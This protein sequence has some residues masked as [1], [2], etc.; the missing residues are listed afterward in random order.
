[1]NHV[2][3]WVCIIWIGVISSFPSYLS[4]LWPPPPLL[5]PISAPI[6][7]S[8]ITLWLSV[9]PVKVFSWKVFKRLFLFFRFS[10]LP[11]GAWHWSSI[12]QF[13]IAFLIYRLNLVWGT[14]P[15]CFRWF[16]FNNP[17]MSRH[18]NEV[19]KKKSILWNLFSNFRHRFGECV[20]RRQL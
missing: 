12:L 10:V 8:A 15:W 16:R 6:N 9:S 14:L 13:L 17:Q 1:M 5:A 19:R 18:S 7:W 11:Q 20:F 2:S 3:R 4:F